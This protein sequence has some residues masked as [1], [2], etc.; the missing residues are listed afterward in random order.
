MDSGTHQEVDQEETNSFR[1]SFNSLTPKLKKK[2]Q[3][4]TPVK[5]ATR[6]SV[7][8]CC[9]DTKL[10]FYHPV[11]PSGKDTMKKSYRNFANGIDAKS[12]SNTENRSMTSAWCLV[13][14][15]YNSTTSFSCPAAWDTW[16]DVAHYRKSLEDSLKTQDFWM[17]TTYQVPGTWYAALL[18]LLS[19]GI[20]T[21]ANKGRCCCSIMLHLYF[22]NNSMLLSYHARFYSSKR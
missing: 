20:C 1:H 17:N 2:S 12:I 10:R 15:S 9:H 13:Q 22:N 5:F 21:N 19:R 3:S 8:A 6:N 18:L 7:H 11:V 16:K 14:K 4:P